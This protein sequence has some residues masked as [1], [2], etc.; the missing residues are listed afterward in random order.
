MM[1]KASTLSMP[2]VS[3]LAAMVGGGRDSADPL[4]WLGAQQIENML[5]DRNQFFA[6]LRKAQSWDEVRS[7]L[8]SRDYL[9]VELEGKIFA[10][11]IEHG[12]IFDLADC[13]HSATVFIERL[14]PLN[15]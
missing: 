3:Q 15:Q 5:S 2:E 4:S 6:S 10:V 9:P 13:G 11:N 1:A 14:G 7:L 12:L 8:G